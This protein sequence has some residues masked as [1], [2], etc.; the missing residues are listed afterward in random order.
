MSE[1]TEELT[2]AV[3]GMSEVLAEAGNLAGQLSAQ[4]SELAEEAAGHGWHGIATRMQDVA[5]AL[6]SA[7]GHLGGGQQACEDASDDLGLI[8]DK[9]P[10]EEVVG[11]L[12]ASTT[13]LG[14]AVTSVE[15]ENADEA[16]TAASEIGQEGMMQATSSLHEQLT[17]IHQ[18]ITVHLST[19]ESEQAAAEVYAKKQPGN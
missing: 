16:H 19:S 10:A 6:E 9:I 15:G 18:Q 8:N 11:H 2:T 3:Q 12:A 5:A 14:V 4:A 13:Q 17:D 1:S 7:T